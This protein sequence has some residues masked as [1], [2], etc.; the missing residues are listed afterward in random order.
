MEWKLSKHYTLSLENNFFAAGK[1]L[2]YH[3][4]LH[5]TAWSR[6]LKRMPFKNESRHPYSFSVVIFL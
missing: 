5:N 1:Y 4:K 6:A 2:T 3:E